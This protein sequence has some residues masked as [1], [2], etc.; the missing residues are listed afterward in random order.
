MGTCLAWHSTIVSSLPASIPNSTRSDF[1]L[2]WR[3]AF[4]DANAARQAAKLLPEDID[5]THRRVLGSILAQPEYA[6]LA[7]HLTASAKVNA[8]QAWHKQRA[9]AGV[10]PALQQLKDAG[11]VLF[12]F[13][14]GTTRLQLNL[15]RSAG[16]TDVFSMLFSSELLGV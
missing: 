13:A 14:N 5:I 1:A 10:L 4:F 3:Q 15:C 16:L 7:S 6:S 12:V 11:E 8:I 9:R 2:Q